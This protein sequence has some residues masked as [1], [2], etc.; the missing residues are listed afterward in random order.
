MANIAM[1]KSDEEI[2][3]EA[4]LQAIRR[5]RGSSQQLAIPKAK[6]ILA[7]IFDTDSP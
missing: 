7:D 5:L 4:N 3:L 2:L 6:S 1:G